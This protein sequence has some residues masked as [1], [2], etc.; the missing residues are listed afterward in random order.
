MVFLRSL[1][2]AN[3]YLSTVDFDYVSGSEL[4]VGLDS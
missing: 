3:R 4:P 1:D 2:F